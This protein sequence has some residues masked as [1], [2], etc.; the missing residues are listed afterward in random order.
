M[1]DRIEEPRSQGAEPL[2]G[3]VIFNNLRKMKTGATRSLRLAAPFLRD[4]GIH[5]HFVAARSILHFLPSL[6]RTKRLRYDFVMFNGLASVGSQSH[7]GYRLWQLSR[8]VRRPTLIYWHETDWVL[9]QHRRQNPASARRVDR[10]AANPTTVHLTA[11]RACSESIRKHYPQ[12]RPIELYEC[13]VVPAPFD[14]P[15]LPAEPPIVVN[16]ASIQKRKGTG[17]FVETA[18]KVCQRHPTVEFLWLG[19]GQPFGTWRAEIEATGLEH[20]ILFPGFVESAY[21]SLRRASLCFL[22][23]RDDPFPLS[24]LEAMCLGR[25]VVAFDV[26]GAPEALAGLGY[27]VPPFDTGRAA[28][29]ILHCLSQPPQER[30][31]LELR[32][33]YLDLYTPAR[34]AERLNRI[35]REQL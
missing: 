17:L 3:L 12:A 9:D 10:L 2:Y 20:R 8:L 35:L 14:R 27:L 28:E 33:R 19:G 29:A 4:L 13:A 24:V 23:S 32:Q 26:G 7:F 18:I 11:S 30:L 15:I 25:R 6:I 16:L 21:L 5:L 34:F 22:S 1:S 31:S